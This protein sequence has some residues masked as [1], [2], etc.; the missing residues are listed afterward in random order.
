MVDRGGSSHNLA[1]SLPVAALSDR[2]PP[3]SKS[4]PGED[5]DAANSLA[6]VRSIG[7][8]FAIPGHPRRRQEFGMSVQVALFIGIFMVAF[9]LRVYIEYLDEK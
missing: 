6:V 3:A 7:F 9:L 5:E 4:A 2:S 8:R 1:A